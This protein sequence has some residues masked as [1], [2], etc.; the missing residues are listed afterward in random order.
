VA[1]AINAK[2][3]PETFGGNEE[4]RKKALETIT[5]PKKREE[6]MTLFI[7]KFY[8]LKGAGDYKSVREAVKLNP[9]HELKPLL[10]SLE[11]AD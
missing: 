10:E 3:Y 8:G 1:K 9:D 2:H 7:G 5:D 4:E 6:L 11:Q